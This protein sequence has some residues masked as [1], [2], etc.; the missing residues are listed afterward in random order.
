M[1][2]ASITFSQRI[3]SAMNAEVAFLVIRTGTFLSSAIFK[4][5][6]SGRS[7]RQKTTQGIVGDSSWEKIS[8]FL[9]SVIAS[10]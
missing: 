3:A 10:M 2:G 9:S 8:C 1:Q 5:S 7:S 4:K 6:G